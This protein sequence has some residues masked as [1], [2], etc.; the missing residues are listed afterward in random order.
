MRLRQALQSVERAGMI[1]YSLGGHHC[2][3]PPAVQQGQSDDCFTISADPNNELLWRPNAIQAKALKGAN[4]AS[5]FP[6]KTLSD[7]PLVLA[8][9]CFENNIFLLFSLHL[10][11]RGGRYYPKLDAAFKLLRSHICSGV[12]LKALHE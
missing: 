10:V 9:W 1:E 7:S 4:L 6:Y 2:A 3:R 8:L 11:C 12:A 5:H